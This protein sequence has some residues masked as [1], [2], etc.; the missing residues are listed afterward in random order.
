MLVVQA[1]L[2]MCQITSISLSQMAGCSESAGTSCRAPPGPQHP[3]AP[4]GWCP[5]TRPGCARTPSETGS[6]PLQV[7]SMPV[8][9]PQEATR[10]AKKVVDG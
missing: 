6:R 10:T 8:R 9:A 1:C 5:G 2:R 4:R 3:S 7:A